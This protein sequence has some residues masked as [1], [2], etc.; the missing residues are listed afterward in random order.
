LRK[1]IVI[2]IGM[3]CGMVAISAVLWLR[4]RTPTASTK[5][6]GT[7]SPESAKGSDHAE[8]NA[9]AFQH[10]AEPVLPANLVPILGQAHNMQAGTRMRAIWAL[11][12]KLTEEEANTLCE[13]LRARGRV[14]GMD[15]N[16]LR[17]FKNEIMDLLLSRRPADPS[18]TQL[19]IGL[20]R[21]AHQDPVIRDYAIQHLGVW[22]AR[23]PDSQSQSEQRET[24]QETLREALRETD[25]SIA[26]TSLLALRKLSDTQPEIDKAKVGQ[27]ALQMAE[28]DHCGTLARTTALSVCGRMRVAG[29]LFVARRLA[30][31]APSIPLQLSAIAVLGDLGGADERTL[32]EQID[33]GSSSELKPAARSSLQRLDTKERQERAQIEV[34]PLGIVF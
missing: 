1:R 9:T 32:L 26:G 4:W 5:P 13:F 15:D 7:V 2:G 33:R 29:V 20:Y 27:A 31:S 23:I 18:L 8:R 22:Y 11:R 24:I 19:L 21:D 6:N 16:L 10:F 17:A 28:D 25:S 3:V 12:G 34:S 14:E 30:V